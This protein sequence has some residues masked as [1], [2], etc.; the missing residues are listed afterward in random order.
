MN[1]ILHSALM[2][3]CVSGNKSNFCFFGSQFGLRIFDGVLEMM[4][5]GTKSVF[6]FAGFVERFVFLSVSLKIGGMV[7]TQVGLKK[8]NQKILVQFD[9]G[10]KVPEFIDHIT[11]LRDIISGT[12]TV[13]QSEVE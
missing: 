8:K 6:G 2:C 1:S 11:E 9:F 12:L 10:R 7:R 4:H 3:R 5:G 13:G